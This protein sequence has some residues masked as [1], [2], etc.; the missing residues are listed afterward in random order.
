MLE[1][2]HILLTYKCTLECDHC[3]L[4]CG[5]FMKG[6]FTRKQLWNVIMEEAKKIKT[7]KTIYFEG[8]EPLLFY[9]LLIEG[10]KMSFAM[11]FKTGVVSNAY[12]SNSEHDAEL[13]IKE[14]FKTGIDYLRISDD[15]F[16]YRDETSPAKMA[17]NTA[18]K[19][20]IAHGS[21]TIDKPVLLKKDDGQKKG[22]AVIGGGVKLKGR[23]VDK[24]TEGLATKDWHNF[25]QCLFED[26]RTP[27]RVHLD[28]Y[29][30]V[31]LCQG[32]S[33]G[34]MWQT[35]LSELVNDYDPDA[36]PICGPLLRGGPAQLVQ[37]YNI[38][39]QKQYVDECHLCYLA[40]KN[41]MDQFPQYLA[42]KQVYGI[43]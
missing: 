43:D 7:I 8:G 22:E 20:Q 17:L 4:H 13:W 35:P 18:K 36:H 6:T 15:T 40:R 28:S 30:N 23:A 42:P 2:L 29:G 41:L 5:P 3:F 39:E 1:E 26:L 38:N 24:L 27:K 32:I 34:N 9:P 33:M 31:H 25:S 37:E 16:H 14:L 19:L 10:I 12:M 11:G 21:I